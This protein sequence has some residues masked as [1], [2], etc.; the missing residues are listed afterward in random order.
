MRITVHIL[1]YGSYTKLFV[2]VSRSIGVFF[3]EKELS[4]RSSL[5]AN[6]A[7]SSEQN[8]F[9]IVYTTYIFSLQETISPHFGHI[10]QVYSRYRGNRHSLTK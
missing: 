3:V 7:I 9:S 5:Q 10:N 8:F 4:R 6:D 2:I 1:S